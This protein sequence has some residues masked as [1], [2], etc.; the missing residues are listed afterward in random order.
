MMPCRP[1][2]HRTRKASSSP[3][4]WRLSPLPLLQQVSIWW[5]L[6]V[7]ADLTTTTDT[8]RFSMNVTD[9]T[10]ASPNASHC[11]PWS[12]PRCNLRS[13]VSRS[14]VLLIK[15]TRRPSYGRAK[16]GLGCQH[17]LVIDDEP[18]SRLKFE[19]ADGLP[20][21]LLYSGYHLLRYECPVC[22]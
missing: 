1:K 6:L 4:A 15:Q 11:Y 2:T 12:G 8:S 7:V 20:P 13:A 18:I 14:T 21:F 22:R 17:G 5:G 19:G 16:G 10:D 3:C 9:V